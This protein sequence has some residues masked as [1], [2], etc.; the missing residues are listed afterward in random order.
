MATTANRGNRVL[1][2]WESK[3]LL[4]DK[5]KESILLLQEACAEWPFPANLQ[6]DEDEEPASAYSGAGSVFH[7]PPIETAS[8]APSWIDASATSVTQIGLSEP[9]ETTQQF[10]NWFSN[11]EVEMERGQEDIYRAYLAT[12]H[13]YRKT[14]DDIVESIDTTSSLLADLQA[15]YQFVEDKTRALQQA[16]EKLL[17]DQNHLLRVAE[18]LSSRL[19]YFNELEPVTKLFSA[20]GETVC[21]DER[22]IPMLQRLD[23]CILFVSTHLRYRDSELYLMRFRQC[24]TRGMS[25]I[26]LYVVNTLRT[27]LND[28][29][30]KIAA[31]DSTEPL[32]PS[33]QL[34]LFY[35]KFRTLAPKL[36]FLI[37]EIEARCEGHVE[38]Y[39]LLGDCYKT[40][41]YVRQTLLTPYILAQIQAITADTDILTACRSGCAYMMRLCADEYSLFFQYFDLGEEELIPYLESLSS[42]LYE[43]LRPIIL[44]EV[45]IDTLSELCQT[46]HIYLK[47]SDMAPETQ[48][49][50]EED[51]SGPVM[52]VA[53]KILE[54]AQQRLVFRAQGYVEGEI[55]G[56]RPREEELEVLARGR[57]LPQ[58]TAIQTH[59]SVAPVLGAPDDGSPATLQVEEEGGEDDEEEGDTPTAIALGKL[60]Y[61][62]GEWYPTVQRTLYILGK[63]YRCVPNSIFE[64][65]AQEAVDLCRQSLVG[66]GDVIAGKQTKLDGQFFL[67]KNLLM[68]REQIAPFDVNFVR[69]EEVLEFSGLRDAVTNIMQSRWGIGALASLG[70]GI[71]SAA[72]PSTVESFSDAKQ[73]VDTELKRVCEEFIVETA[74]GC[75]DGLSGFLA[76][77]AAFQL[78]SETQP[79]AP[80]HGQAFATGDTIIQLY[81]DFL[82]IVQARMTATTSKMADY[83]GDRKTESVLIGVVKS[84]IVDTYQRFWEVVRTNYGEDV[85]GRVGS[86]EDVRGVLEKACKARKKGVIGVGLK[87]ESGDSQAVGVPGEENA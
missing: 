51:E 81:T 52:F 74:K 78:K 53:Q 75:V 58:P 49:G 44:R 30:E 9:I 17:E 11:I 64:D 70:K 67:I 10:F 37:Q 16:C 48:R 19:E 6:D 24:M 21:L 79:N 1:E 34:S 46:L 26:K 41:F 60:V 36:K 76:K 8:S 4:D 84:N 80:L 18:D 62:G 15:N 54:D 77:V 23:E 68:L 65:L 5:Q 72:A 61:G 38:Y 86:V 73:L 14:C 59:L 71:M 27:T 22:F 3:V 2:D 63:L 50:E 40:Y 47:S 45:R 56:F 20:P 42:S 35:V 69:K 29:R 39:A 43:A 12:V 28:I 7:T 82:E 33:M 85:C 83:L 25:L 32:S 31:R 55:G 66:A 13:I 57:G 87:L